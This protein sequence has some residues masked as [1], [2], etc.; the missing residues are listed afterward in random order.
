MNILIEIGH[1]AHVYKLLYT[2]KKLEEEK[3]KIVVVT[4]DVHS[5]TTLLTSFGIGY[6]VIGVKKDSLWLKATMQLWYNLRCFLIFKKE[7]INLMIGGLSV[8]YLTRLTGCPSI[9][10]DDDDDDAEPLLVK[11]VHPYVSEILSPSPLTGTRA[12]KDTIYYSGYHELAYLHPNHFSPDDSIFEEIGLKKG[13]P[14]FVLR[15]NAFKAH[16]DIGVHG[17][18]TEIKRELI[19]LLEKK[20]RVFITAERNI[21]EEFKKYQLSLSPEKVHSL[22]YYAT[23]FVGDSQTMTSEAAILGTPAVKCNTFAGKLSIPNELEEK[24]ELCYA[25][26]PE[27]SDKMLLKVKDLLNIPQLKNL[28]NER[29]QKMLGDKIDVSAFY[30]W[31]IENYPESGKTMHQHSDYQYTFK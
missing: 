8:A 23:M 16:H 28:W 24:Y 15:F 26:L 31:F 12:R 1:P 14:Y 13:E 22:L 30:F 25:F 18:S 7:K 27:E 3:H 19:H 9:L 6:T 2:I 5:V 4:K 29:K 20:G 10:F 21:D 11:Y 17:L